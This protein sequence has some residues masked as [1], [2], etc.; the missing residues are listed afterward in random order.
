MA[1]LLTE[2]ERQKLKGRPQMAALQA[3]IERQILK[4]NLCK[5]AY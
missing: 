5:A 2:T 1:P 4:G 3:E